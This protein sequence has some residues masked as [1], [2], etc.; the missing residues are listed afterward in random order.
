MLLPVFQDLIKPQW[1]KVL[2]AIKQHG[3]MAVGDLARETGGSYMAAKT[4]CEELVK[5]GYL[6]RTRLPRSGVG[7]PEI[8]YNLASK[9]GDLFPGA[10]DGFTLDL[11][12]DVRRIFGE[13]APDKLLYQHF[14]R[15]KEAWA[16]T[17][18]KVPELGQ[19]LKKLAALREKAGHACH[20]ADHNGHAALVELHH[21]LH[22][23]F[24]RHPRAETMEHRMLEELLG[25]RLKRHATAT[26]RESA[27]QVTF[28]VA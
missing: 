26:G 24:E 11:L 23:I 12:E 22:R 7:R 20:I 19:K 25:C 9:A 15:Q 5:A 6:I 16:A 21:P 27:A 1:R 2:E 10:G 4:H 13:S 3:G 8:F 18:D 17:I 28:E 14:Q